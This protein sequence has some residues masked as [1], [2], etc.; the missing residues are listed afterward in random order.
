MDIFGFL[1]QEYVGTFFNCK[2]CFAIFVQDVHCS[3]GA[4]LFCTC[5]IY[6]N[7][8]VRKRKGRLRETPSSL[9]DGHCVGG[10]PALCI[11]KYILELERGKKRWLVVGVAGEESRNSITE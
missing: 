2:Y 4:L 10:H 9:F 3:Q 8:A 11:S 6:N 1:W 5:K 7:F